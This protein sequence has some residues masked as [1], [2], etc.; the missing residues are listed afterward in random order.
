MS[1]E[2]TG[3]RRS[4]IDASAGAVAE[5]ERIVAQ[6]RA[7]WPLRGRHDGL[8]PCGTGSTA[9]RSMVRII[10]RADRWTAPLSIA[11]DE[12]MAWAEQNRVD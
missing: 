10:L 4:D 12:L 6:I 2:L 5:I 3:L 9:P 1:A 7:R 8:D 11:R